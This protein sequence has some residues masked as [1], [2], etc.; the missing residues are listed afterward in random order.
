MNARQVSR[1]FKTLS[2]FFAAPCEILLTGAAAGAVYGRVRASMDVDFALKIK[3]LR[4]S[5]KQN[6]WQEFEAA[7]VKTKEAT[8]IAAQYA[9]DID[10]WSSI[11]FL[12]YWK[13]TRPFKR[14]GRID[15]QLLEPAYWAI[16]KFA[17]YLDP[18]VRDM[19]HVFRKTK[20][21]W[22][23]LARVLGS[24]LKKSPK[25][26]ACF[27]F[28]RQVEDFFTAYG[29]KVWGRKFSGYEAIR[30]F[31]KSAGIKLERRYSYDNLLKDIR[32]LG[33]GKKW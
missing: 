28:R 1:Y 21:S 18:D 33:T 26:T 24:A 27:L 14:F 15:V 25:S 11:S 30:L 29:K 2:L 17:R 16:G 20:T 4:A 19:I 5:E 13:H 12:D 22:P 23:E 10:R 9:E 31:H 3:V 8:G 32:A 6:A 7:A